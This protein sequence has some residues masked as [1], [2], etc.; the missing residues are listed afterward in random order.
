MPKMTRIVVLAASLA[1]TGTIAA[2]TGAGAATTADKSVQQ[3]VSLIVPGTQV[4]ELCASGAVTKCVTVGTGPSTVTGTVSV[5]VSTPNLAPVVD[6]L[7]CP[8]GSPGVVVRAG[9][10]TEG[11]SLSI[12]FQGSVSTSGLSATSVD[13][14]VS[15]SVPD[16]KDV[17]TASLCLARG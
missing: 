4:A 3:T 7:P 8:G 6:V 17:L 10:G 11:G 15:A 1:L 14:T 12:R 16:E 9:A 5:A 13:K 2:A